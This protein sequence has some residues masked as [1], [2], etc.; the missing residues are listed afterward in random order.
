MNKA[1]TKRAIDR[2]SGEIPWI[3][4]KKKKTDPPVPSISATG[5]L[6]NSQKKDKE[7]ETDVDMDLQDSKPLTPEIESPKSDASLPREATPLSPTEE[8][9]G[10]PSPRAIASPPLS[11][12]SDVQTKRVLKNG[13]QRRPNP[14]EEY[15][16]KVK[17]VHSFGNLQLENGFELI[18]KIPRTFSGDSGHWRLSQLEPHEYSININ[19][20]GRYVDA[21]QSI[22]SPRM[23]LFLIMAECMQNVM[24]ALTMSLHSKN[25][26]TDSKNA[27]EMEQLGA[28]VHPKG[29]Y[30]QNTHIRCLEQ[31]KMKIVQIVSKQ[32]QS[33]WVECV[34]EM[35]EKN[36]TIEVSVTRLKIA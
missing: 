4:K 29:L 9:E 10:S 3:T 32:D 25:I 1:S 7:F 34:V 33:P 20:K 5:N 28:F 14:I 8:T 2:V 19:E 18:A 15:D 17:H 31:G 26:T 11:T 21:Y 30:T 24:D 22:S 6:Q 12:K 13:I 36:Q 23:R 27:S 16:L 35:N